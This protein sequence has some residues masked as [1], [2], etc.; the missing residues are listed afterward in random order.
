MTGYTV[1]ERQPDYNDLSDDEVNDG[2]HLAILR[3]DGLD[4]LIGAGTGGRNGHSTVIIK[5]D[6][7][8]AWVYES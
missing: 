2:D 4:P 7:G 6:K 8:V 1:P 3:L 5:D